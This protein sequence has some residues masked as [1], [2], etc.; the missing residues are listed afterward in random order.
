M[1]T[2]TEKENTEQ[3]Q[4]PAPWSMGDGRPPGISVCSLGIFQG[5]GAQQYEKVYTCTKM[6]R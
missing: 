1:T 3:Q 2:M 6:I 4:V 5:S